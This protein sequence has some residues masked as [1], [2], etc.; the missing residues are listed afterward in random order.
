MHPDPSVSQFFTKIC[1][2]H[3]VE[4][5][6]NPRRL[7]LSIAILGSALKAKGSEHYQRNNEN[8]IFLPRSINGVAVSVL[9][10]DASFLTNAVRSELLI[11]FLTFLRI[12]PIFLFFPA[13]SEALVPRR[14]LLV[15]VISLCFAISPAVIDRIDYL[16]ATRSQLL[17][18]VGSETLLG[19]FLGFFIRSVIYKIQIAGSAISSMS[20][21]TQM[22][23]TEGE[24]MPALSQFI[25]YS[26]IALFLISDLHLISL[27]LIHEMYGLVPIGSFSCIGC[28][29]DAVVSVVNRAFNGG[30]AL[31]TGVISLLFVFY[32]FSGF[33]NKAMP[34]FM[35]SLVF[36]PFAIFMTLYF[37]SDHLILIF[38]VWLD[39]SREFLQ[40]NNPFDPN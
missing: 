10:V 15:F 16:D 19:L 1:L 26:A 6:I 33:V 25:M 9:F 39:D 40:M 34:Q 11:A 20:S 13:F 12:S 30:I 38:Q 32:L 14:I 18:L 2:S 37:L 27:L 36:A 8:F 35:V 28:I 22:F 23:Q 24:A 3:L 31:A 21:I 7:F 4:I 5:L 29:A 17:L